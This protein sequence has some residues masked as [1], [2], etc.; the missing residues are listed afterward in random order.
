MPLSIASSTLVGIRGAPVEVEVDV[1]TGIPAVRIVGLPDAAVGEARE[2]IRSA[3]RA[4]GFTWP[5]RR[6]TVNLAPADLRKSG[7]TF[8]LA[9]AL[10]I[11]AAS[12]QLRLAGRQIAAIGELALDGRVRDIPGALPLALPLASRP[13]HT[14]LLPVETAAQLCAHPSASTFGVATL[15]EAVALLHGAAPTAR[16]TFV[17]EGS[18]ELVEADRRIPA[19]DLSSIRGQPIAVRAL[20]ISAVARLPILLEGPPGVGK[21]MLAH[22]LHGILPDLTAAEATE[23]T[24]IASA[25]GRRTSGLRPPLR[26]PHHDLT[27]AGLIGGGARMTPGELTWAHRGLLVLDEIGEFRRDTLEALREPLERGVVRLSRA[28]RAEEFP[29]AALIVATGNP[30]GCGE[31]ES[32]SGACLCTPRARRHG[33]LSLSAPI[34]DRFALRVRL[35]RPV[36]PISTLPAGRI[37]TAVAREAVTAAREVAPSTVESVKRAD[38]LLLRTYARTH[39]DRISGRG[40][41]HICAVAAAGALL[42][43]RESFGEEELAEALHLVGVH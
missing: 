2:R 15:S 36:A 24:A 33:S 6:I 29:A 28:G 25:A 22:A 34:R 3:I 13:E 12:G 35:G 27:V 20:M 23:V 9:I 7:G 38:A 17:R 5:A 8:D 10:G 4:S 26:S 18:A 11:L 1:A 32:Q 40:W 37:T 41:S 31:L 42:S 21:S 43:G 39:A 16:E 30:C 14:L 19:P